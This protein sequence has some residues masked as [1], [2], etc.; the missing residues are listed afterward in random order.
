MPYASP[1]KQNRRKPIKNSLLIA[2]CK[3]N[4]SL[5]KTEQKRTYEEILDELTCYIEKT[6]QLFWLNHKI[7]L[8]ARNDSQKSLIFRLYR[9][10]KDHFKL[11][12]LKLKHRLKMS[13]FL[14]LQMCPEESLVEKVKGMNHHELLALRVALMEALYSSEYT[15]DL[16]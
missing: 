15:I 16:D 1:T 2:L 7:G 4:P 11:T 14:L 10:A 6:I 9:Q 5:N 13:T 8:F 3:L 12:M